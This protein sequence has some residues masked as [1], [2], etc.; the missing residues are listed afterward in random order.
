MIIIIHKNREDEAAATA[1]V[2]AAEK[3]WSDKECFSATEPRTALATMSFF[4]SQRPMG[5]CGVA[6]ARMFVS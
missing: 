2:A 4:G 3:E 5:E 1:T 6:H